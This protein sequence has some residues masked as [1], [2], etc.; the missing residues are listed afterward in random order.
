[1]AEGESGVAID[2]QRVRGAFEAYVEG[3]DPRDPK[4]ALKVAHTYRVAAL[5]DDIARSLGLPAHDVDLAWLCG[6][7]HD[8]GRF[9]QVRR[10]ETFVDSQSVSHAALGAEVLFEGAAGA[11]G[12]IRN[13]VDHSPEDEAIRTAVAHHSDLDLPDGLDPATR[14]LC[15]I[16]RDADKVD[17]LKVNNDSPVDDIYPFG[18]DDL[19]RSAVSPEVERTFY[20]HRLVPNSIRRHP[21]DMFV[22]HICFMWGLVFHRSLE[23]MVDQGYLFRML[24]R[25]FSNVDTAATFAAMERHLRGWL[26]EQGIDGPRPEGCPTMATPMAT[27]TA[28]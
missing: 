16:V 19:E 11:A 5:C 14:R 20:E 17:I 13:Y 6:M 9:E 25:P 10:Y 18:E 22:G 12:G 2:R 4:I 8:V 24:E 21:A 3:Y 7:L 27:P 1:M 15:D 26:A 28:D 23:L